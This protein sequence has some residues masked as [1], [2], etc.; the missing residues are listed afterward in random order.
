M[1][2]TPGDWIVNDGLV[3]YLDAGIK[4]S[5]SGSG[6]T[7]TDLAGS[8][9]GT[10]TN[11]PTYSGADGGSIVFDGV[12]DQVTLPNIPTTSSFTFEAWVNTDNRTLARQYIYTKQRTPPSGYAYTFQQMQGIYLSYGGVLDPTNASFVVSFA[13]NDSG[14]TSFAINSNIITS[15]S[16]WYQV[17]ATM[18]NGTVAMYL[19][20]VGYTPSQYISPSYSAATTPGIFT[21]NDCQ[22]GGRY[23][24]NANDPFDGKIAIVRDYNR[25]L[26]AA[27]VKQNFEAT[28]G[29]F[30]I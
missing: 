3:L 26:S 13:S 5:Y 17:V 21:P 16:T 20:G 29:R 15:N 22:V 2:W 18:D 6:T 19:N 10:L 11:G 1:F 4:G 25:A 27:E 23:D 9:N 7:W 14:G 28:R 24:S 8:N 30:G 12:N